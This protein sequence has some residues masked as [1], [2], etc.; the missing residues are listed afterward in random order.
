MAANLITFDAQYILQQA[1]VLSSA[2]DAINGAASDLKRASLHERWHCREC[3]VINDRLSEIKSFLSKLDRGIGAVSSAL[4][5]GA[6]RFSE[7]E[8]RAAS[9]ADGLGNDLRD[10]HGFEGVS[11]GSTEN[12]TNLN[13]PVTLIPYDENGLAIAKTGLSWLDKTGISDEAGLGKD[14]ISYLKSLNDFLKGEKQGLSGAA[15]LCDLTDNS[16]GLWAGMYEY[17]KDKDKTSTGLGIF[18]S[19]FSLAG[20]VFGLVDKINSGNLSPAG[21]AGEIF[22][23][24]GD[25]VDFWSSI[26]KFRHV[27]DTGTNIT[28]KGGIT[29]LHSPL[30]IYTAIGKGYFDA[31]S[32]GAK[33]I[34]KYSADGVW[35]LGDT[36]RTG[37][38]FGVAG[39]YGIANSLTFGGL[40]AFGNVTGFTPENISRDIENWADNIGKRAGNYIVND[41]GLYDAYSHAGPIGKT[42]ITFHAAVQSGIQNVVNDVG[43]WFQS[44]F[45]GA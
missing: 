39:L 18:S 36:G 38:E 11:Y 33:S 14:L 24:G 13:L 2:S 35:D 44:L 45:R 17:L 6:A 21:I 3:N 40:E 16:I 10:K 30:S 8:N 20:D 15:D 29:G 22:G 19:V 1:K 43:N 27:A 9:Q 34:E 4:N 42:A 37:T 5:T 7:L 23:A 26:E 31:F 28:T 25:A 12:N 41:P 32:Q